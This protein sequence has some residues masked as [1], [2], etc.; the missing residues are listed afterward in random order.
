[1]WTWLRWKLLQAEF[2][3]KCQMSQRSFA[4]SDKFQLVVVAVHPQRT[5]MGPYGQKCVRDIQ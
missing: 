3:G 4:E 5:R 2:P 1:M